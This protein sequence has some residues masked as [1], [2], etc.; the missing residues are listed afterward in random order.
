MSSCQANFSVYNVTE[1]RLLGVV[2]VVRGT[3]T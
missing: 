1:V 3:H 2:E